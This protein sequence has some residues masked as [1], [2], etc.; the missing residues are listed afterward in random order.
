M[1]RRTDRIASVL[2]SELSRMLREDAKDPRI[3]PISITE[4]RVNPDLSV[5]TIRYVPLGGKMTPGLVEALADSARR[6]RGPVGRVLGTRI[7]PE[8]R[9][10]YDLNFEHADRINR[11]LANLPPPAREDEEE[12]GG[13]DVAGADPQARER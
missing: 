1:S 12:T 13:A 8:L 7:S 4:I 10:E 5:A 6:F 3:I 9:F 11:L 2:M